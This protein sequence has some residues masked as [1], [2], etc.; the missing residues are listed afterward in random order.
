MVITTTKQQ[1]CTRP[2]INLAAW[3]RFRFCH[4][5]RAQIR[6]RGDYHAGSSQR[7]RNSDRERTVEHMRQTFLLETDALKE[8]Q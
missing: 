8:I 6:R 3:G 4:L 7:G 5:S 1:H 2:E